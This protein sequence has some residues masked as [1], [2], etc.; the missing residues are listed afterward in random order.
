[1]NSLPGGELDAHALITVVRSV[2]LPNG[3]VRVQFRCAVA[4]AVFIEAVFIYRTP[5]E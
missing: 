1:M 4:E 2:T 3:V 5:I